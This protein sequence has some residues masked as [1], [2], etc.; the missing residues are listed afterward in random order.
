[1]AN[2]VPRFSVPVTTVALVTSF[3]RFCVEPV[4]RV[5]NECVP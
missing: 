1:M 4:E 3:I 5:A 2:C